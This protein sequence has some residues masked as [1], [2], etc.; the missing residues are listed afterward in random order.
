MI[1]VPE[2]LVQQDLELLQVTPKLGTNLKIVVLDYV[3]V[4]A[5][6]VFQTKVD[7][8]GLFFLTI[9]FMVPDYKKTFGYVYNYR[10]SDLKKS[11]DLLTQNGELENLNPFM[12]PLHD[13]S[14]VEINFNGFCMLKTSDTEFTGSFLSQRM[15]DAIVKKLTSLIRIFRVL[16]SGSITVPIVSSEYCRLIDQMSYSVFKTNMILFC[17]DIDQLGVFCEHRHSIFQL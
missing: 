5:G 2:S 11:I 16:E 13:I 15:T 9:K 6:D 8:P 14:Q 1:A 3:Q 7:A 17:A 4:N 12:K 10:N